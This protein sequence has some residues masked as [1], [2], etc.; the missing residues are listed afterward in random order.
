MT[1]K[2]KGGEIPGLAT[3]GEQTLESGGCEGKKGK[4]KVKRETTGWTER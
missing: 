2:E 4:S 3:P 1:E